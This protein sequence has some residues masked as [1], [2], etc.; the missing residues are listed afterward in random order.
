[1]DAEEPAGLDMEMPDAGEEM[2]AEE[3]EEEEEE[4]ELEETTIQP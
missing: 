1:M 4:E 3:E 2:G